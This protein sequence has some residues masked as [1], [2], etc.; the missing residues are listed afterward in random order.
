MAKVIVEVSGGVVQAVYSDDPTVEVEVLDH[1]E[2][3][4]GCESAE[5]EYNL[6][7]ERLQPEIEK[8]ATVF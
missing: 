7:N 8:M 2:A 1:D 4:S 5:H 3:G 6:L